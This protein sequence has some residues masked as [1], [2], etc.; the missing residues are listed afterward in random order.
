MMDAQQMN[1]EQVKQYVL[2]VVQ[3]SGIPPDTFIQLG[4]IAEQVMMDK[5]LYPQFVN[6]AVKLGVADPE[7]FSGKIDY[8]TIMSMISVGRV[9]QQM[10]Q[11]MMGAA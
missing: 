11:P 2:S 6:Q 9:C 7:D 10:G 1:P 3:Q 5:K 8:E 4:K